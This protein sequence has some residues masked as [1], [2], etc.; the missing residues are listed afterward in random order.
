LAQEA[1]MSR[2]PDKQALQALFNEL[3]EALGVGD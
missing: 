2:E 1:A 3:K